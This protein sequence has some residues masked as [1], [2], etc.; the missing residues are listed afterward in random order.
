MFTALPRF[1]NAH[2]Q[3]P[4]IASFTS[5]IM[6]ALTKRLVAEIKEMDQDKNGISANT[7]GKLYVILQKM[8]ENDYTIRGVIE[9][10][11]GSPYE[12][13]IFT[14][15][16]DIS[17]RYPMFPPK[18]YF[19]NKLWHPNVDYDSGVV[20]SDLFAQDWTVAWTLQGA[21]LAVWSALKDPV[22]A[23]PV[24]LVAT[25]QVLQNPTNFFHHARVWTEIHAGVNLIQRKLLVERVVAMGFPFEHVSEALRCCQWN[26]DEAVSLLLAQTRE[27]DDWSFVND[28]AALAID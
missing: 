27:D 21:L 8:D 7:G 4:F 15:R 28:V 2:Q 11:P 25:E 5:T 20:A 10:P 22:L 13:G 18:L 26:E 23:A 1:P 24:N 9:G 17:P 3:T 12:S 6:V 19:E 14:I 16:M